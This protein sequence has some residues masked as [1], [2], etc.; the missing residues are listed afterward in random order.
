MP[1]LSDWIKLLAGV[2]VIAI[3]FYIITTLGA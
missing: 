1:P 3:L 2:A